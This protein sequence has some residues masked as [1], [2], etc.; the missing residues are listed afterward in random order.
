MPEPPLT[1]EDVLALVEESQIQ[2]LPS[3][4]VLLLQSG[5]SRLS[6]AC[7]PTCMPTVQLG[8]ED[9]TFKE[10]GEQMSTRNGYAASGL[11]MAAK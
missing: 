7:D 11:G 10:A 3:K 1:A 6:Y 9:K 5:N 2:V 8:D 4:A